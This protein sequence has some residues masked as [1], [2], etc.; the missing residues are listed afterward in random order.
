[1]K[2]LTLGRGSRIHGAFVALLMTPAVVVML[3]M[4]FRG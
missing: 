3:V 2:R 1:M 4:A